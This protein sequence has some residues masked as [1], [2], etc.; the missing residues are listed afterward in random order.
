MRRKGG[1]E[2]KRR[3]REGKGGGEVRRK[4]QCAGK[5]RRRD[6]NDEIEI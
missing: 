5:G 4:D 6:G 2:G 1:R 3:G